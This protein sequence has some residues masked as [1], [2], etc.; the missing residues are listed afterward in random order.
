MFVVEVYQDKAYRAKGKGRKTLP[1]AIDTLHAVSRGADPA[2]WRLVEKDMLGR[3]VRV[4][5]KF[6]FRAG[7]GTSRPQPVGY[8]A[9]KGGARVG[10]GLR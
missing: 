10:S 2:L 7:Q 6:D 9:V 1:A 8:V 5:K 3:T 4:V